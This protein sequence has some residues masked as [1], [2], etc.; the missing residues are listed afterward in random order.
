MFTIATVYV[1]S[2]DVPE[3]FRVMKSRR[4]F[5]DM[6]S[7]RLISERYMAYTET[8]QMKTEP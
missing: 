1:V 2:M 3:K 7:K 8:V 5:S 6:R 4:N